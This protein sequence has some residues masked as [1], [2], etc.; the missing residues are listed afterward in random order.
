MVGLDGSRAMLRHARMNAADVPLIQADVRKFGLRSHFDAVFC[1]FDSL[2]HLLSVG[3]LTMA[4]HS[5]YACLKPGGLLL[6]DVNTELGYALHWKGTQELVCGDSRVHTRSYYDADRHLGVFDVT[7]DRLG[8]VGAVSEKA[9]LWQRC[10][11][12]RE[13][14]EALAH[15]GFRI[16]E[17]YGLEGDALVSGSVERS[18]RTFYLCR[19]PRTRRQLHTL[20]DSRLLF[21]AAPEPLS[22]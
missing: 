20:G 18:E 8:G 16:V 22:Q 14:R 6:F 12:P 2:N 3:D 1:L 10:H 17:T 13:I 11:S 21:D 9:T 19:R 7:T 15:A 5:V 4:F